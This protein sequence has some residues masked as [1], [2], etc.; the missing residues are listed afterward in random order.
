[1]GTWQEQHSGELEGFKLH[2]AD[3]QQKITTL[4][5]EICYMAQKS[6]GEKNHLIEQLNDSK[7]NTVSIE[8]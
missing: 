2:I 6:E 5:E 3:L 4:N 7:K 8:N 1:M